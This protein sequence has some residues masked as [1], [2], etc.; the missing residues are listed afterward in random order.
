MC[1]LFVGKGKRMN[2]L[3][4]VQLE[5]TLTK[6]DLKVLQKEVAQQRE[7]QKRRG[8]PDWTEKD[9]LL[10]AIQ[11]RMRQLRVKYG[12]EDY[13]AEFNGDID[14][15]LSITAEIRGREECRQMA[16]GRNVI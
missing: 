1:R 11:K 9:E 16:C 6:K 14:K 13:D 10:Y 12:E 2:D 5:V 8:T 15:P 7:W 3:V 4:K